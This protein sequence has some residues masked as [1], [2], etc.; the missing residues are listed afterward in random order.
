MVDWWLIVIGSVKLPQID[1]QEEKSFVV[2]CNKDVHGGSVL[3]K[4]RDV[5]DGGVNGWVES[6]CATSSVLCYAW[7]WWN[8]NPKAIKRQ[9][10]QQV[11]LVHHRLLWVGSWE[12]M[13]A[14]GGIST[15][16]STMLW[17][18]W[19]LVSLL[20]QILSK[21]EGCVRMMLP[22]F[23]KQSRIA[24]WVILVLLNDG[25]RD[26]HGFYEQTPKNCVCEQ[27]DKW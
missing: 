19:G 7:R 6:W 20:V 21:V 22:A 11:C 1:G 9:L 23:D 12:H 26:R 15:L 8:P 3:I 17:L 18:S 13:Q 24:F 27:K 25:G 2:R 5:P 4:A 14:C 16:E 10:M